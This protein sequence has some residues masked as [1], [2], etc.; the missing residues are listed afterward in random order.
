MNK[1]NTSANER[2]HN[3][4]MENR[5]KLMISG[6]DEVESFEEDNVQLKT[7]GGDLTLRGSG[8]KMESYVSEIGDLAITG[9]VYALVYINDSSK[10]SGFFNRLFK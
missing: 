5:S 4:I 6:V 3:V 1:P 7:V 10:K 2:Q 9:N 8:M